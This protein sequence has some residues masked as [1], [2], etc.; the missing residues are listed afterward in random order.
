MSA[1]PLSVAVLGAGNWG[2]TLAELSARAGHGVRLWTRNAAQ[3]D[4][5][6]THRTNTKAIPGLQIHA[7]VRATT[8]LELAVRGA[9]LVMVVIPTQAMRQ[10]ARALGDVLAPEQP[11]IHATKGLEI[12]T[13]RRVSEILREETCARQIGVLSGPN[14]AAEVAQGRPAGTLIA[15]AFPRVIAI[16]KRAF[17]SPSFRVFGGDDVLGVE[18][19]GALKNVVALAAGMATAMDLGENAKALLITRGSAEITA[20]A[21]AMGARA[22]TFAG[23]AGIGD[24]LVTC[25]SPLS[26]NHRAGAALARGMTLDQAVASLGQV[27]EGVHT[28]K[29]ARVLAARYGVDAPLL[30]RVHRV[31]YDGLAPKEALRQLM[32]LPAGREVA[33]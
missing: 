20:I 16:G 25:A 10:V 31:L 9:D 24:L 28:A 11:V 23:L 8:S 33:G 27:A 3:A 30:D 6:N 5:I 17:S 18:L 21:G 12:G 32:R 14:L 13:I 15:S 19:A 29:A 1:A 4:E 2:N 22:S 7:R 26:R